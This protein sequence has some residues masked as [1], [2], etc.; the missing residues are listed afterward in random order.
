M[1]YWNVQKGKTVLKTVSHN[2][3]RKNCHA[4]PIKTLAQT[5]KTVIH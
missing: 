2:K 1:I 3:S 4:M 5:Q